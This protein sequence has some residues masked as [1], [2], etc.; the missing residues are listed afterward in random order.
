MRS[1]VIGIALAQERVSHYDP[2]TNRC[3]VELTV[4]MAD[5]TR[6]GH[7]SR[8]LYD[9]QTGEMLAWTKVDMGAQTGWVMN[10]SVSTN[11]F[12]AATTKID[13]LMADDRKQ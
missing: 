3:Y 11:D 12:G 9:G 5:L 2:K 6:D 1:N 8:L 4:H 7:F 10:S 13:A